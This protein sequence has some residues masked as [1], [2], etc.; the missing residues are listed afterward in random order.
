ETRDCAWHAWIEKVSVTPKD[1]LVAYLLRPLRMLFTEP[2]LLVISIFISFVYA[3]LYML[4]AA[5][6]FIYH[7]LSGLTP[8]SSS[9]PMISLFVGVMCGGIFTILDMFRYGKHIRNRTAS[10]E[11]RLYPMGLGAVLL[12]VGLFWFAFTGP[13]QTDSR[14]GSVIALPS[15]MYGMIVIFECGII[16]L[17]DMNKS[18]ANS[19]LAANTI[20]RSL[21][22]GRFPLFTQAMVRNLGYRSTWSMAPLAFTALGLAPI[23]FIFYRIRPMLRAKSR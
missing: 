9:L 16:Y 14:W 3:L 17:I 11:Q 19:A 8:V 5:L 4:M 10:P 21:V 20:M 12:P 18:L 7:E 1:I 6:P 22:G 2:M 15:S 23:P 13:A